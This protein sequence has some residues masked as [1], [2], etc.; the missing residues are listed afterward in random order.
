VDT[1]LAAGEWGALHC[2]GDGSHLGLG[3]AGS[4]PGA[5]GGGGGGEHSPQPTFP[6]RAALGSDSP[7]SLASPLPSE[8]PRGLGSPEAYAR[9]AGGEREGERERERESFLG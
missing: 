6:R 2:D 4:A 3:S 8:P 5:S 1:S 7:P 9:A